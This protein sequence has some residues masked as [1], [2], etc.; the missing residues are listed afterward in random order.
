MFKVGVARF[1]QR[2]LDV[3]CASA[4]GLLDTVSRLRYTISFDVDLGHTRF[5]SVFIRF[6]RHI[7]TV[8]FGWG[9]E[10]LK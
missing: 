1:G 7:I 2:M 5:N 4:K 3:R 8:R 9:L 6:S 10:L